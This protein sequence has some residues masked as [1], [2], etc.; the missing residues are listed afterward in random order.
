[1]A[2]LLVRC[3]L[4]ASTWAVW[5]LHG[6]PSEGV[7]A[8]KSRNVRNQMCEENISVMNKDRELALWKEGR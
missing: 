3:C 6:P 5:K 7:R 1:M 4:I 8:A 2:T